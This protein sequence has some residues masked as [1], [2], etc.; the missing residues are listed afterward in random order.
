M[1]GVSAALMEIT[2]R[3]LGLRPELCEGSLPQVISTR[4]RTVGTRKERRG[5]GTLAL[6]QA[7]AWSVLGRRGAAPRT[8]V[9]PD[10]QRPRWGSV[11]QH[12][13]GGFPT[14]R[15]TTTSHGQRASPGATRHG[16]RPRIGT[17]GASKADSSGL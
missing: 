9:L 17:G 1:K 10:P 11:E 4:R 16:R 7:G 6:Q 15:A 12:L 14:G 2:L 8:G 3:G 13:R 5:H